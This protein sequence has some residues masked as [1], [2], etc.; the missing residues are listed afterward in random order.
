MDAASSS[1]FVDDY[2][3]TVRLLLSDESVVTTS[4]LM[5][6]W[7]VFAKFAE[8]SGD[9]VTDFSLPAQITSIAQLN[10]LLDFTRQHDEIKITHIQAPLWNSKDLLQAPYNVPQWAYNFMMEL[11]LPEAFEMLKLGEAIQFNALTM[12]AAAF[13]ANIFVSFSPAVRRIAGGLE[14]EMTQE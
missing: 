14:E 4:R 6:Y 3:V 8:L 9:R 11:T 10:K 5:S 2:E 1:T 7:K 13:L 12:L